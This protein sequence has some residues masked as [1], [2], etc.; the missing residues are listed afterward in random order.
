MK[1]LRKHWW[2]LWCFHHWEP[3]NDRF[4]G[5]HSHWDVVF[6]VKRKWR[7]IHCGKTIVSKAPINQIYP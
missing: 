4:W 2:Q 6:D 5:V 1:W 7:C 3:I